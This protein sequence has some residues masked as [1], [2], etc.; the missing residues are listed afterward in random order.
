MRDFRDD[1]RSDVRYCLRGCG[2][3]E[4][5][6]ATHFH[7]SSGCA[8]F[9]FKIERGEM[10]HGDVDSIALELREA[11]RGNCDT[12]GSRRQVYE[13]IIATT[14][15]FLRLRAD[16]RGALEFDQSLRD[17]RTARILHRPLQS[18]GRLLRERSTKQKDTGKTN[19]QNV[20]AQPAC[21]HTASPCGIADVRHRSPLRKF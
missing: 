14:I 20:L 8:D 12:V 9:K 3:N 19:R 10:S 18:A 15:G 11:L 6:L 7:D 1:V 16:Q 4:W 21:N 2:V 13:V 17:N 5:S